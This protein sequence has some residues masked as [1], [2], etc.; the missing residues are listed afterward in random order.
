MYFNK[1]YKRHVLYRSEFS[2]FSISPAVFHV[3]HF[4]LF[5]EAD[6]IE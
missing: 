1:F 4:S 6:Y 2:L 3:A 5:F